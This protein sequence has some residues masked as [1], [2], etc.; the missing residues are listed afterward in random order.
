MMD[1]ALSEKMDYDVIIIGGGSAGL[2]A[3][4]ALEDAGVK[5]IILEGKSE[6][7]GRI[8]MNK[9]GV[10]LG[11]QWIHGDKTFGSNP[12]FELARSAQ[13]PMREFDYD[14]SAVYDA[15]N[16]GSLVPDSTFDVIEAAWKCVE[17][18]IPSRTEPTV[19]LRIASL[20]KEFK[21]SPE[22]T[23]GVL[24]CASVYIDG[25]FGADAAWLCGRSYDEGIIEGR[26]Y[27]LLEGM[28]S[29]VP[30]MAKA[31]HGTLINTNMTV[32]TL[33][34]S[35]KS[36]RVIVEAAGDGDRTKAISYTA[37]VALVTVP[38]GVLQHSIVISGCS[39][40]KAGGCG[41]FDAGGRGAGIGYLPF[42]EDV[43]AL[44]FKPP[45]PPSHSTAIA[46]LGMGLLNKYILEWEAGEVLGDMPE[47]VDLLEYVATSHMHRNFPELLVLR[48]PNSSAHI[49]AICAFASGSISLAL[50][51]KDDATVQEILM[52]QL[53][54]MLGANLPSP[55]SFTQ[56]RWELDPYSCGAYSFLPPGVAPA[57]RDILA[58]SIDNVVWFAGEHVCAD[59][60]STIHGAMLSGRRA[61][62][63]IID[64]LPILQQQSAQGN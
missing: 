15:A 48:H 59:H 24:H 2:A 7:G 27:M 51:G 35:D 55:R 38:L 60:P 9:S 6:L 29:I 63:S 20:L 39:S 16:P 4:K 8:A 14:N 43:A 10:D 54:E 11:A 13:V 18:A 32:K 34:H 12:L 33:E 49:N 52:T 26:D 62:A 57:Q 30:V 1:Y 44:V 56:T 5:A 21:Y 42:V 45:L 46:S 47:K 31:L 36:V 17:Q 37:F 40:D 23:N 61:A 28:G 19:A 53:R 50:S 22:I 3:A 58:Q 41:D 25:E 64:V